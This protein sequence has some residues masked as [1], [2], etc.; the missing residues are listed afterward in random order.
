MTP[1]PLR[2]R[3]RAQIDRREAIVTDHRD[4]HEDGGQP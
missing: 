1:E 4:E 3:I 2:H